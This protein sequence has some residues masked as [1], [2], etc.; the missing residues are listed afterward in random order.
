LLEML[1]QVVKLLKRMTS[2]SSRTANQST[3]QTPD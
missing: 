3:Q 2:S 1:G